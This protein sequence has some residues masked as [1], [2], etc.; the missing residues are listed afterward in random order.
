MLDASA[1][2]RDDLALAAAY[3]SWDGSLQPAPL[4]AQPLPVGTEEEMIILNDDANTRNP[5]RLELLAVSDHAYFWFESEPRTPI[6]DTDELEEIGRIFDQ[7]YERSVTLFGQEDNPGV[8]GDPRLHIVNVS[9]QV[10]CDTD[11]NSQNDCHVAGYLESDSAVPKEIDPLSNAR[12]MFVM[13]GA[14]FGSDF[15][16]NVLA[17][18]LR[19][20][21]DAN[22]DKGDEAWII[23]GGATLAEDLL[24]FSGSPI[25]RANLFLAQP[26][27]QLNQ[28]PEGSDVSYYGKGYLFQRYIF[29]RLGQELYR[30]FAQSSEMGL[31]SLDAIVQDND[32]ATG[33]EQLWQD[34][35]VAMAIHDRSHTPERFQFQV[36]GLDRVAMTEVGRFPALFEETVHQYA[37]DYYHIL[38]GDAITIDFQGDALVPL[39]AM[40]PFSGEV[41]WLTNRGNYS[42]MSLTRAVDLSGVDTATLEYSV[43]HD[44]EEGY[45]FAYL[46]V[47]EDG[48][49]TWQPLTAPGMQGQSPGDDPSNSAVAA[50][51]Y[52]GLSDGW[53]RETVDLSPYTG[54]EIHLR[55][56]YIT[57]PLLTHAGLAIDDIAIPEIGFFDDVERDSSGW[58]ADGFERVTQQ[59]PQL[60][61]LQLI[62]F[63]RDRPLVQSLPLLD[64]FSGAYTLSLDESDGEAILIISAASPQTLYLAHYRLDISD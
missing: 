17:H 27:Q 50:R 41:I 31:A 22:H 29:D 48:G 52:T 20:L 21:I 5:V 33:G 37:A 44:I 12:E 3:T 36:N 45:D 32:L 28:W 25:R 39:L 56:A 8:D 2:E 47:S 16:L 11:S 14:F 42:H 30:Q 9:P 54:G 57:D 7:I 4:R 63:D 60:W 35:L 40:Q 62:T 6:P 1:P 59:I 34:W 58:L 18:E 51:F 64:G 15:Y 38:G 23:E 55:F 46:F 13:N 19:H 49:Q 24:G 26:D 43:Y 10:L 53:L 61:Q